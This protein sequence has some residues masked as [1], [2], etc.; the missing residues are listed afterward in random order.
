MHDICP[1]CFLGSFPSKRGSGRAELASGAARVKLAQI[2]ASGSL[3]EL[4][5]C[6]QCLS[7]YGRHQPDWIVEDELL[8]GHF[9]QAVDCLQLDLNY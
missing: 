8:H 4:Y 6:P 3:V 2:A 5:E 9:D 1:R 7:Q